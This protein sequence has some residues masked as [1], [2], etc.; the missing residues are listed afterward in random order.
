MLGHSQRHFVGEVMSPYTPGSL[1]VRPEKM[2]VGRRFFPFGS[3]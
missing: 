2:M 1:T 3:L